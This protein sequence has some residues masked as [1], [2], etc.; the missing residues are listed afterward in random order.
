MFYVDNRTTGESLY[1][2]LQTQQDTSKKLLRVKL[3]IDGDLKYYFNEILSNIENDADDLRTNSISKF[4]FYNFNTV[5]VSGGKNHLLLRHLQI[6]DDEYALEKI[7]NKSWSYFVESLIEISNDDVKYGE[8]IKNEAESNIIEKT[9]NNLD[10]CKDTYNRAFTATAIHFK[11]ALE[12]MQRRDVARIQDE[13]GTKV[14][15]ATDI[16]DNPNVTEVLRLF[17]QYFLKT[18]IFP[19]GKN[20]VYVPEGETPSFMDANEKISVCFI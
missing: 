2:F 5:R 11:T 1:N 16:A 7:Q 3:N 14:Y 9:I 20:L 17:S 18:G 10:Y 12:H 6:S 8:V 13:L 15:R 4:L 19:T